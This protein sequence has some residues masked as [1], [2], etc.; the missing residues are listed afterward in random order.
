MAIASSHSVIP[1]KAQYQKLMSRSQ[2]SRSRCAGKTTAN[3]LRVSRCNAATASALAG[4]ATK[5][6]IE[7][8]RAPRW[9]SSITRRH[10]ALTVTRFNVPSNAGVF[11][12]VINIL[13]SA[14]A[15]DDWQ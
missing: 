7:T 3:C 13:K 15:A 1:C 2:L 14:R 6:L 9:I 5:P 11:S 8:T 12:V 4:A 10:S